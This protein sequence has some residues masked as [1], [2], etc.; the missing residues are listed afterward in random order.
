MPEP[1][2]QPWRGIPMSLRALGWI[3]V[4]TFSHFNPWVQT[5]GTCA[6]KSATWHRGALGLAGSQAPALPLKWHLRVL[7]TLAQWLSPSGR[8]A[9]HCILGKLVVGDKFSLRQIQPPQKHVI[10][11]HCA[12]RGGMK[13]LP[14]THMGSHKP[15]AWPGSSAALRPP[16]PD[17]REA[18][19]AMGWGSFSLGFALAQGAACHPSACAR[20]A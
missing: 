9:L 11:Q 14:K 2:R 13:R 1:S 15:C 10:P 18:V 17:G 16:A 6:T 3:R 8:A 20:R 4:Y 12:G 5:S 19:V 7:G